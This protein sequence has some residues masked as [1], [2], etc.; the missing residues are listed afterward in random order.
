MHGGDSWR[1][2]FRACRVLGDRRR[3]SLASVDRFAAAVAARP[4]VG[5]GVGLTIGFEYYYV[6]VT[7]RWSYSELMPRV[8]PLGTGL[9]PLLQWIFVPLFVASLTRRII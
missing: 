7:G 4:F 5:V 6:E 8:P 9:Y 3:L 2:R 1:R